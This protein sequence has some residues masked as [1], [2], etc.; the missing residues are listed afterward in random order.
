V[1]DLLL[2]V[3]S[4]LWAYTTLLGLLVI[5]A[6]VPV[7]PTQA[8]MITGGALTVYG[9]LD[10]PVLI[11]VGTLGIFLGDFGCYLAGRYSSRRRLARRP[12][13]T[14]R[15][16]ARFTHRLRQ[17]GPLSIMLCRFVPGGRM[18]ACFHA[19]RKRYPYR[20]FLLY[21]STAALGWAVYGG[22]VGHLGGTALTGSGWH[23]MG[24]A[25]IAAV[26]FASAGWFLTARADRRSAGTNE[27]VEVPLEVGVR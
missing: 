12:R 23:L 8:L 13:G 6:V 15:K 2:S 4:P 19:G 7:V 22:L 3:V 5:D 14:R 25:A 16:V 27:A 17:P 10:L 21:E 1:T 24:I 18:A 11:A 20:L 9:P 26:L